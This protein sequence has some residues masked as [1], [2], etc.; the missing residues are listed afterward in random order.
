MA[1][2]ILVSA[3]VTGLDFGTLDFGTSDSG[4]TIV[5]FTLD[6]R[7]LRV[8]SSLLLSASESVFKRYALVEELV[9]P[10]R[11]NHGN[12]GRCCSVIC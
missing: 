1:P 3:Q 9:E 11:L 7:P 8:F 12:I 10:P 6:G 4:L 2:V 5:T